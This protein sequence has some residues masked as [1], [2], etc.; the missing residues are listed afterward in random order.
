MYI[1]HDGIHV[2]HE[3]PSRTKRDL[4]VGFACE[5]WTLQTNDFKL[6]CRKFGWPAKNTLENMVS[7]GASLHRLAAGSHAMTMTQTMIKNGVCR[8]YKLNSY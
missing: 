2:F 8:L 7:L 4:A 6:R 1:R 5:K 3:D